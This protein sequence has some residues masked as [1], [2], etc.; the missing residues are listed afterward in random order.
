MQSYDHELN[1]SKGWFSPYALD[2]VVSV[3]ADSAAVL[4]GSVGSLNSAGRFQMGLAHNAMPLF[5]FSLTPQSDLTGGEANIASRMPGRFYGAQQLGTSSQQRLVTLVATGAFELETTEFVAG[6]YAP[7]DVLTSPQPGEANAGKLTEGAFYT[8]TAC[9]M[10]S[11]GV[12]ENNY[13]KEILRFWPIF[14][15]A[16]SGSN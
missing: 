16:S 13:G 2:K 7:N 6:S 4:P 3:A 15:P 14:V 10:V 11:D 5:V 12:A 1:A 8:T 9:G